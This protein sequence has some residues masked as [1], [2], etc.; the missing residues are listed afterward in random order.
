M[1][2]E[3]RWAGQLRGLREENR[4]RQLR[5]PAGVDFTSN[6]YLGYCGGRR[7]APSPSELSD[8]HSGMASR[9]LRG[10]HPVWE[11]VETELARWQGAEAALMFTSGYVAN[12]GLLAT[13][14]EPGDWVASDA[15]NH[16]SIIDGLRLARAERFVFR[17]ND[18]NHLEEGLRAAAQ[19]RTAGRQLFVVTESLFGMEGDCCALPVLVELAERYG[20]Q[21]IVDEAHATGCFGVGGAGLVATGDLRGRVLATVHTGGK[22]LGVAGA[23][24]CGSRRLKEVLINRCRHFI[25]TTA[26]PPALGAWWL[27]AIARVRADDAGRRDL[28]FNLAEFRAAL[29]QQGVV[30]LGID[31]IVPVVLGGDG[32]AVLAARRLQETGWD[33]RAIRPPSVPAGTARLRI[34]IHADHERE[35]LLAAAAAVSAAVNNH[36]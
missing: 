24:V 27:G 5:L 6:D 1:N 23:C 36:A 15:L 12:E 22:A 9:L 29:A 7:A 28:F 18:L 13:V 26:L 35:T 34:A 25:F 10:Q 16:A 17:H 21:V 30:G 8:A 31:F 3:E 19:A 20:A 14:I 2:L 4:Y 33:I 11:Q 32:R